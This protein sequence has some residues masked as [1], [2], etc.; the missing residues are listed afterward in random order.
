MRGIGSLELTKMLNEG[1]DGTVQFTGGVNGYF[2][3]GRVPSVYER[4][5]YSASGD[6][7]LVRTERDNCFHLSSREC[8]STFCFRI[9]G[10]VTHSDAGGSNSVLI[11]IT[12]T[13]DAR[14]QIDLTQIVY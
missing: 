11:P 2:P 3:E 7:A 4:N 1:F 13:D 5:F 8:D 10:D 12:L 14:L 9:R 6:F